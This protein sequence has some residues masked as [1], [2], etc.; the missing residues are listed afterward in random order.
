MADPRIEAFE[1]L[2]YCRLLGYIGAGPGQDGFVQRSDRATAVKFFDRSERFRREFEGYQVLRSAGIYEMA[3]HFV[4][5]LI[6]ADDQLPTIEMSIVER[7]FLLDFAGAKL[8]HEIPDFEPEVMEE[9]YAH[10]Q[11]LFGERWADALHVAEM[12]R[13]QTGYTLLDIHPGNIAFSDEKKS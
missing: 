3:G 11:D 13:R 12:F 10:M 2:N 9:H 4:P 8:P 1:L 6:D 7:P 5:S